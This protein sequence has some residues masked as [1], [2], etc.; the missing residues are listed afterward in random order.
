MKRS[1]KCRS[2]EMLLSD[3]EIFSPSIFLTHTIRLPL[4]NFIFIYTKL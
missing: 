3:Q 1:Y 2:I 4:F